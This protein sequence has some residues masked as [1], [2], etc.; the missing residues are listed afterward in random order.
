MEVSSA[1]FEPNV[2]YATQL[3]SCKPTQRDSQ[4]GSADQ[5]VQTVE[6]SGQEERRAGRTVGQIEPG[7]LIL[8]CL[9]DSEDDC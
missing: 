1:R 7:G 6:P 4:E 9:P 5:D 3:A 8:D 2:V